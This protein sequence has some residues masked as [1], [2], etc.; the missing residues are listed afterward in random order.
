MD[1]APDEPPTVPRLGDRHALRAGAR[2]PEG[3]RVPDDS[4][5]GRERLGGRGGEVTTSGWVLPAA[6]GSKARHAI[7]WSGLVYPL[8]R[9][10]RAGKP[11]RRRPGVFEDAAGDGVANLAPRDRQAGA[12]G[13]STHSATNNEATSAS[14]K[15]LVPSKVCLL[16]RLGRA[17]LA[18]A[19]WAA[20]IGRPKDPKPA[21]RVPKLDL[22]YYGIS[23]L[24][25]ARDLAWYHFD[26]AICAH[27]RGDDPLAL[28]DSRALDALARAV[29]ARAEAMGFDR[30]N[31]QGPSG[32]TTPYIEFLDQLP[33]LLADQERRA[34]ERTNPPALAQGD[35]P[36]ARVARL[37]RDLDQVAVRQSRPARGRGPGRVADHPA[38]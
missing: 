31:R 7:A 38:S 25:L 2:R 9:G 36:E 18:E 13:A 32:G 3:V 12:I 15:S 37:I 5:Q 23:Y 21:G 24:T 30:R 34:R 26:R 6:A 14:V 4:D 27:M 33:E 35:G 1:A 28:A 17:D 11:R 29:E 20:A 22:N 19:V 16:L 8:D 10:R